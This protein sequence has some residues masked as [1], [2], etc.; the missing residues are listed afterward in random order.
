MTSKQRCALAK[1]YLLEL[2]GLTTMVK[3][4]E[5]PRGYI[6]VPQFSESGTYETLGKDR[7]R[8]VRAI[9]G[10]LATALGIPDIDGHLERIKAVSDNRAALW[11]L[12]DSIADAEQAARRLR[13][14]IGVLDNAKEFAEEVDRARND[15]E[16]AF[17]CQRFSTP[18]ST[19]ARI[20]RA[21]SINQETGR[22]EP[23][24]KREEKRKTKR[25][26]K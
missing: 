10:K 20:A 4:D 2:L 21:L 22:M 13:Y 16:Q 19:L 6:E 3:D 12:Q 26:A 11:E 23:K 8:T 1:K 15:I 24:W 14:E 7:A 9:L 17:S 25:K 5:K 18:E